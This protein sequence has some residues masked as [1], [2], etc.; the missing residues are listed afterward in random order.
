MHVNAKTHTFTF[1]LTIQEVA[2]SALIA[3]C[4]IVAQRTVLGTF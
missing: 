1:H 3:F 2:L 4:F